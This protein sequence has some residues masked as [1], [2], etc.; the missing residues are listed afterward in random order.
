MHGKDEAPLSVGLA[1]LWTQEGPCRQAPLHHA[2]RGDAREAIPPVSTLQHHVGC[3]M[4]AQPEPEEKDMEAARSLAAHCQ[5]VDK[6]PAADGLCRCARCDYKISALAR[7]HAAA[8]ASGEAAGRE[9]ER[10]AIVAKL[11]A[12]A[13]G[14]VTR[15]VGYMVLAD[16]IRR[17]E[18]A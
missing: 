12:E 4:S 7:F 9:K 15:Q 5:L 18:H 1:S 14:R 10:E 2:E 13:R 16:A 17:G 11:N 8:Y 6:G 3:P